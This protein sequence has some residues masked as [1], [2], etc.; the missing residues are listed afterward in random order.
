[1]NPIVAAAI[2][3]LIQNTSRQSMLVSAPPST[4]PSAA[5]NADPPA[6]TPSA[7]PRRSSGKTALTIAIA[8]GIISAAPTPWVARTAIIQTMS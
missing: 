3:T 8:V 7:V 4:G 1:M 6:S 5:K 2:G